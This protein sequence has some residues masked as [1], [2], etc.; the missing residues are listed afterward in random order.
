MKKL[1]ELKVLDNMYFDLFGFI[2][3]SILWCLV[4]LYISSFIVY[5]ILL[6]GATHPS[7]L[8][9]LAIVSSVVTDV[10]FS[11]IGVVV[12]YDLFDIG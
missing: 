9:L 6:M 11:A 7:S 2:G 1:N 8:G 10:F 4:M 3:C 5:P 12:F